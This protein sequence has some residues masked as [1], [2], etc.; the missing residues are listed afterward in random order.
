MV[1]LENIFIDENDFVT[2]SFIHQI[3]SNSSDFVTISPLVGKAAAIKIS[4]ELLKK[5]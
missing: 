1:P 2:S 4:K 3:K 5:N